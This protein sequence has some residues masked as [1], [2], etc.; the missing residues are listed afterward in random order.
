MS[1]CLL[2][3]LA[4]FLSLFVAF[5]LSLIFPILLLLPNILLSCLPPLL[6]TCFLLLHFL[7]H[8]FVPSLLLFSS[9]LLNLVSTLNF[10]LS[11]FLFLTFSS[12]VALKHLHARSDVVTRA[13]SLMVESMIQV[14]LGERN[15]FFFTTVYCLLHGFLYVPIIVV[16]IALERYFK[17]I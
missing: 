4:F 16:I 15:Y 13:V 3:F 9:L 12:Q 6:I 8:S 11:F 2:F 5:F 7:I 14:P 10:F 1:A 17:L